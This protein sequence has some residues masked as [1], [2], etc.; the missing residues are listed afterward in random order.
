V[1]LKSPSGGLPP[2]ELDNVIGKSLKAPLK[3]DAH[4]LFENL[5]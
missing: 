5:A 1:A 3:E 2:F 4:I